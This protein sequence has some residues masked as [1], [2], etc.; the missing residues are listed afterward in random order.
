MW[1]EGFV[2]NLLRLSLIF[3]GESDGAKIFCAKC[4]VCKKNVQIFC[5]P[6]GT[7]MHLAKVVPNWKKMRFKEKIKIFAFIHDEK[8]DILY[9]NIC[10]I[11][12]SHLLNVDNSKNFDFFS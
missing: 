8:M 2:S 12:K 5:M 6:C 10:N 9:F 4:N 1:A 11:L 7:K 3:H